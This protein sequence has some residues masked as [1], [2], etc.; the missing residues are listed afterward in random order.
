[1][2]NKEIEGFENYLI[3][4]DGR[5]WS[6]KSNKFLKTSLMIRKDRPI[7]KCY[8]VI[9][10]CNNKKPYSKRF[11]RLLAET[12]IPNPDNLPYVDHIDRN[13]Q[14]N[15]INNLRW[16]SVSTNGL[17]TGVRKNNKLGEKHISLTKYNTY[18]FT[19][20]SNKKSVIQKSFKTLEEAIEY[21]N[22]FIKEN[23]EYSI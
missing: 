5:I 7:D 4:D 8:N 23:P 15:N 11:H 19:I 3:Y 10:L 22:E 18:R 12:F 14:N 16:V 2:T 6:K 13:T 1:M 17:N 20:V 21:R 9:S